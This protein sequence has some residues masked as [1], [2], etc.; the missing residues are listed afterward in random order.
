MVNE[1]S[2]ILKA[3][4]HRKLS[5]L[6]TPRSAIS[7]VAELVYVLPQ[8]LQSYFVQFGTDSLRVYSVPVHIIMFFHIKRMCYASVSWVVGT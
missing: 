2:P 8:V 6:A 4:V 7:S 1:P 5:A 3:Y